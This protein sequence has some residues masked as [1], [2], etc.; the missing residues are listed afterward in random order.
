MDM[1]GNPHG[2][3]SNHRQ[4][5]R[6]ASDPNDS[7]YFAANSMFN[8]AKFYGKKIFSKKPKDYGKY[9][10]REDSNFSAK[11][12]GFYA[13]PDY[14]AGNSWRSWLWIRALNP[15]KIQD[16]KNFDNPAAK[17]PIFEA[18]KKWFDQQ[19]TESMTK[20]P[21]KDREFKKVLP[22]RNIAFVLAF[23]FGTNKAV[24]KVVR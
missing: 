15:F 7:E 17:D 22:F 8:R 24:C 21:L 13:R 5:A 1:D 20:Q 2:T 11:N 18:C 23:L 16:W 9:K 19:T 4:W 3:K 6:S 12:R 10:P 14:F